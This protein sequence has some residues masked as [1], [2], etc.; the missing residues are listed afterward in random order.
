MSCFYYDAQNKPA[1]ALYDGV[2]YAYMYNLQGDVIALVDADG[3]KVVEY[4]YDAWG[5]PLSKTGTLATTLG[6]LNP[7][8]YRGYVYD[9]ETGLYYLRSRYYNP[10]WGRFV[11]ADT[12]WNGS[13]FAYCHNST[14]AY[15]DT[16]GHAMMYIFSD[17]GIG[18]PH[19]SLWHGGGGGAWS[20]YTYSGIM[21]HGLDDGGRANWLAK[22][23]NSID[24]VALTVFDYVRNNGIFLAVSGTGTKIGL[25]VAAMMVGA[26]TGPVGIIAGVATTVIFAGSGAIVGTALQA[27][28]N[29]VLSDNYDIDIADDMLR[30]TVLQITD[31][32]I[33]KKAIS[34]L[35]GVLDELL[36]NI[37]KAE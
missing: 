20:V 29:A 18:S 12:I 32:L 23:G 8:R 14:V 2:A 16:D 19:E 11:N 10:E 30:E 13:L 17:S 3:T 24:N 9:E 6:T 15:I 26:V 35:I 27:S 36:G 1:V 4:R 37:S 34:V 33:G 5:T 22:T 25:S 7:F 31:A 28:S 21:Q